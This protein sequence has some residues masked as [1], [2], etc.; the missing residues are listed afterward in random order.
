[1]NNPTIEQREANLH[2]VAQKYVTARFPHFGYNIHSRSQ[3]MMVVIPKWR[4]TQIAL[5]LLLVLLSLGM[6]LL[7]VP[8]TWACGRYSTLRLTVDVTGRV[9]VAGRPP[10]MKW[11]ENL[12]A[13]SKPN[14]LPAA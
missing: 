9:A 6:W 5:D 14:Q 1:M 13:F 4:K 8:F 12:D 7:V 10:L 3:T 11:L 2:H